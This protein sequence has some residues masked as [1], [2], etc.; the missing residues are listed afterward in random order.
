MASIRPETRALRLACAIASASVTATGI[1]AAG[2]D[3]PTETSAGSLEAPT[4]SS[5]DAGHD[6]SEPEATEPGATA[7]TQATH[8]D[9]FFELDDAPR[10]ETLRHAE[11]TR[12][13]RGSGGRSVA[14]RLTFADGSRGYFKPEQTFSGTSFQAEVAAYHVDRLLGLGRTPPTVA[15]ALPWGRLQAVLGAD[16]RA[17]EVIVQ[18]DG[19]V[20]GSLS[21]W[22]EERLVPLQLGI[23]F[24]RW[25]RVDPP[26]YL[27]PF[28]RARVYIAQAAGAEPI[29]PPVGEEG[30]PL[31]PA[32]EP[33][34]ADR[35][36]ELSDLILFD[37]LIHN[38][39][40]WG[41][42]FTNVRTRGPGGPLVFLD[43]AAGFGSGRARTGFMD[44]R[45]F[46]V[47]RFRFRTVEAIRA[48]EV[49][50]LRARLDAE[51]MGTLLDEAR[52]AHL[53]ERRA[54]ILA[55]V[56]ERSTAQGEPAT[57]PW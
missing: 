45:L 39:D 42:G 11:I 31:P 15:R 27:T 25:F 49:D 19:T 36:A 20:R 55:H 33:D 9:A 3:A 7:T 50:A 16:P 40:R 21:Y 54:A 8:V 46:A 18:P 29:V 22:I 1:T 44:R 5:E 48:F 28:Q 37:F 12:I 47:Q 10:L 2:C 57:F 13:E 43:N 38:I 26:P 41:G 52:L 14:F 30:A 24:E 34:R 56:A 32:G 51:G 17:A 23:G 35:G 4:T 53:E 6:A